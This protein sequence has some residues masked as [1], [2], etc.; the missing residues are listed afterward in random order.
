MRSSASN[1][2]QKG[3]GLQISWAY[4]PISLSLRCGLPRRTE[5][6]MPTLGTHTGKPSCPA[7]VRF[8]L[9]VRLRQFAV[10]LLSRM[11]AAASLSMPLL[12][13]RLL[14]SKACE[15]RDASVWVRFKSSDFRPANFVVRTRPSYSSDFSKIYYIIAIKMTCPAKST[16]PLF[17]MSKCKGACICI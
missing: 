1:W 4:W 5:L 6:A 9:R 13:R 12:I 16:K 11:H 17:Q 15:S 14:T 8:R 2:A 7:R 3:S 10:L